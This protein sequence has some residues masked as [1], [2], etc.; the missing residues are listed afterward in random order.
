MPKVSDGLSDSGDDLSVPLELLQARS[1][2][3]GPMT[4]SQ[5][6]RKPT[7]TQS[8]PVVDDGKFSRA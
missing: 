6:K 5:R 2:T 8:S 1:A 4:S 3:G 7:A